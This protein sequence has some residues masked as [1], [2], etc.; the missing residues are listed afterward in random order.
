MIDDVAKGIKD[1]IDSSAGVTLRGYIYDRYYSGNAPQNT[2]FP[3]VVYTNISDLPFNTFSEECDFTHWVFNIL[4]DELDPMA[5]GQMRAITKALR[6]LFENATLVVGDLLSE[7]VDRTYDSLDTLSYDTMDTMTYDELDVMITYFRGY[8][9]F[10]TIYKSQRD[11]PE[12][13][14]ILRRTMEFEIYIMKITSS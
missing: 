3:Y 6:A 1:Y 2:T 7:E 13:D 9:N 10:A 5:S 4:T 14:N 8:Q 11:I 12:G